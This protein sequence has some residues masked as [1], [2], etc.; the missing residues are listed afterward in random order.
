[1]AN[2]TTLRYVLSLGDW[3]QRH[4]L[5]EPA[6]KAFVKKQSPKTI[7]NS[8]LTHGM[9]R[10][11]GIDYYELMGKYNRAAGQ[12]LSRDI[13]GLARAHSCKLWVRIGPVKL[14][15]GKQRRT[16]VWAAP[17]SPVEEFSSEPISQEAV[18]HK[19]ET[20][21][22]KLPVTSEEM[23][24][25]NLIKFLEHGDA[26]HRA[27]LKEAIYAFYENKPRPAVRQAKPQAS[28]NPV[29]KPKILKHYEPGYTKVLC[30]NCGGTGAVY[31]KEENHD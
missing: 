18:V 24:K 25:E 19:L 29:D 11:H 7:T 20:P 26:E 9:L 16:K 6:V 4:P 8:Q 21:A 17:G 22:Q 5:L 2:T 28:V 30:G 27:W 10:E 13:S 15:F 12:I 31:M 23:K 3:K 1:M 14:L